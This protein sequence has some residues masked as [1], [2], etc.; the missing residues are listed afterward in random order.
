M[1]EIVYRKF[2]EREAVV[3]NRQLIGDVARTPRSWFRWSA[4]TP[5]GRLVT[6]RARTRTD[7]T[8]ALLETVGALG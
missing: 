1:Y 8:D 6:S 3:V 4:W 7:A 2:G 5:S